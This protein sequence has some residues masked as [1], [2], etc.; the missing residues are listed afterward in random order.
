MNLTVGEVAK[1]F[2]S[3]RYNSGS[4]WSFW[5]WTRVVLDSTL[6][7]LRLHI[8]QCPLGA[9]MVH[10]IYHPDPQPDLHDHPVAFLSIV[11][12]GWY[13]E[14]TPSGP[15]TIRWFNVVRPTDQHRI[16]AMS[17]GGVITLVFCGH[18]VRTW[19]FHTSNGWVPW[20]HYKRARG[21]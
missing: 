2:Y 3:R 5:R 21:E 10:W 6:Y 17:P 15:R 9:V 13:R 20:W 8:L 12:R 11:I 19:G 7:L 1:P 18:G 4:K 14:Q 16:D